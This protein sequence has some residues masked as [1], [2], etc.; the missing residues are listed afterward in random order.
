MKRLQQQMAKAYG[1]RAPP[2]SAAPPPA[3]PPPIAP[4]PPP[5]PPTTREFTTSSSSSVQFQPV[6][7]SSGGSGWRTV[8]SPGSEVKEKKST[9]QGRSQ[10]F[11]SPEGSKYQTSTSLL[12]EE[13][14][15]EIESEKS[16]TL[17]KEYGAF[18]TLSTNHTPN[19]SVHPPAPPPHELDIS[20]VP[21]TPASHPP[22][23]PPAVDHSLAPLPPQP[24][25]PPGVPPPPPE[26][27]EEVSFRLQPK[28]WPYTT[29]Y[30]YHSDSIF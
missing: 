1:G 4:P 28:V 25:N 16:T 13:E 11:V 26:D 17:E 22:P 19:S 12:G 15:R 27:G 5:P 7:D 29:L 24:P 8:S 2:T 14:T 23:P 3:A 10:A 18:R 20:T 21:P 9:L 6:T 30:P